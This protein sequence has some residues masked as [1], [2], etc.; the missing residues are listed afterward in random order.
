MNESVFHSLVYG[1]CI[2]KD[3]EA[4]EGVLSVMDDSGLDVGNEAHMMLV[5]GMA[6]SGKPWAE[7]K[8]HLTS[9]NEKGIFFS[10][11]D[12]F[13]LI[14]ALVRANQTE[15]AEEV[16][17][18]LPKKRGFFQELRNFLPQI[19]F[20]G[21]EDLAFSI[22]KAF[23]GPLVNDDASSGNS[24]R[25]N[26]IF[27]LRAMIRNKCSVD[28]IVD[29]AEKNVEYNN[30]DL[31]YVLSRCLLGYIEAGH[32]EE[33]KEFVAK[34]KARHENE[35]FLNGAIYKSTLIMAVRDLFVNK[36]RIFNLVAGL[37]MNGV[38]LPL[39]TMALDVFPKMVDRDVSEITSNAGNLLHEVR[40]FMN[41]MKER[42]SPLAYSKM[43]TTAI[44]YVLNQNNPE[45]LKTIANLFLRFNV[46]NRPGGYYRALAKNYLFSE[47]DVEGLVAILFACSKL[48]QK[49]LLQSESTSAKFLDEHDE[50]LF[51]C[52]VQIHQDAGVFRP[53]DDRDVI[54]DTI[55][56]ALERY[57]IGVPTSVTSQLKEIVASSEVKERLGKLE[58]FYADQEQYWTEEKS[59]EMTDKFSQKL[60]QKMMENRPGFVPINNRGAIP[61]EKI[62]DDIPGMEKVLKILKKRE[63]TNFRLSSKLIDACIEAG[64]VDRAK[65]VLAETREQSD[66]AFNFSPHAIDHIVKRMVKDGADHSTIES[67][68][69]EQIEQGSVGY[70]ST[71]LEIAAEKSK[72]GQQEDVVAF[73]KSLADLDK[74]SILKPDRIQYNNFLEAYFNDTRTM[75]EIKEVEDAMVAAKIQG[76]PMA[77]GLL[78][79]H[80]ASGDLEAAVLLYEDFAKTKKKSLPGKSILM[81]E[82][83]SQQDMTRMQRV[84][85]ASI[86]VLGEESAL[87][88]LALDFLELGK[89]SQAKK[90]LS[91]PGLRFNFE[92]TKYICDYLVKR[93]MLVALDNFVKF[94][95][96]LFGSDRDYLY[97][98]LTDAFSDSPDKIDDIWLSMQEQCH[99]PSIRLKAKMAD[100]FTAHGRALPF[101]KPTTD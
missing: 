14:L 22:F 93:N 19:V 87:Y 81:K 49:Q 29:M 101:E 77:R 84:L 4:A 2:N 66:K 89:T 7:I 82:L 11:H 24:N 31:K 75:D 70:V 13:S 55:L 33:S 58:E 86:E 47:N 37:E 60:R 5:L 12:Y 78:S 63:Q 97:E 69:K 21:Q 34:A 52:L 46:P 25:D 72:S 74:E 99:V 80:L 30:S 26:G 62:P 54:L 59:Q 95:L 32:L 71:V 15:A 23:R 68:F 1:H 48:R 28:K 45:G 40:M 3:Y 57:H 18:M 79:K 20:A 41:E 27:L 53:N 90:L 42:E 94:S 64:Q 8:D 91:T 39:T 10:D 16:A 61:L 36:E 35:D 43:V 50:W 56:Q 51:K 6:S 38:R 85:D 100:I 73:F 65:E 17:D 44:L 67:F 9:L 96:D 88:D 83:I 98:R 76:I 92:R